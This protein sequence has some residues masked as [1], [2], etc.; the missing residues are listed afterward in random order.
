VVRLLSSS[1]S[2]TR[3]LARF[4]GF[5]VS[6]P[7]LFHL[8]PRTHGRHAKRGFF[9]PFFLHHPRGF[10]MKHVKHTL[11]R[12][13][14]LIELMIVV[15]IIGILAAIAIPAYQQYIT[16]AIVAEGLQ[17]AAG[18]KAAFMASFTT[19]GLSGMPAAYPGTG[20]DT[21]WGY[22]FTPTDN[23][24]AI[25]IYPPVPV[26][27]YAGSAIGGAAHVA[28]S[29]GGKNKTLDDLGLLIL[30]VPGYGGYR[31]SGDPLCRL[32]SND[33]SGVSDAGPAGAILWGCIARAASGIR[34]FSKLTT[35]V[36]ARCRNR[37]G[38]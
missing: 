30:L 13:F 17:L 25:A 27:S 15:A 28:I 36:P 1:P 34:D 8:L 35:Y 11:Q 26:G 20:P 22:T 9:S 29:Y 2:V 6:S 18:A 38:G 14:T 24:K 33:C 16:R 3:H 21:G 7:P 23:V 37:G 12:G 5:F 31:P 10:T 32:G 19:N 4:E